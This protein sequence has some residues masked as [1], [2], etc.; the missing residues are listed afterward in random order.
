METKYIERKDFHTFNASIILAI[1]D[2]EGL[3]K[4]A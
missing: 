1:I 4:Q 3:T 2:N